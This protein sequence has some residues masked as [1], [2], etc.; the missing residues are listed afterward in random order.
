MN[1]TPSP[2]FQ[3]NPVRG[4]IELNLFCFPYAGGAASLYKGWIRHL[5]PTVQAVLV[6]LPGRGSRLRSPSIVSFPA[7]I[8][9]LGE[10]I[11]PFVDAPFVF[12]GHSMGALIGFELA[13]FLR[14]QHQ[15]LPEALLVSGSPAPQIP[16]KYPKTYD[17]PKDEFIA[18][19]HRLGGTPKEALENAELME[20]MIPV[21]RAD[22]E[23]IQNYD[24]SAEAPLACPI[25][26]YGGLHDY[27]VT[28]EMLAAWKE[29]TASTF[30]LHMLPGDHFFL[31][32]CEAILLGLLGRQ[33]LEIIMRRHA[34]RAEY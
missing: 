2:W 34:S 33:L 16:D 11:E 25:T 27:E 20:L 29:Q 26:A 13:R 32:S 12:F 10:A 30:S 5:P 23:L 4:P 3:V 22:F 17:L 6:E 14:R 18:E 31:R 1:N 15:R 7:L 9:A 28:A 19:L 8:A 24:Y 21:L